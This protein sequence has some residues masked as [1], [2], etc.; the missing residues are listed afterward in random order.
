MKRY[1][2]G[3]HFIK[4]RNRDGKITSKKLGNLFEPSS[5]ILKLQIELDDF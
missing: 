2:S 4:M 1:F 5:I 3:I